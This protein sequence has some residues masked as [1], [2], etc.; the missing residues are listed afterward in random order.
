MAVSANPKLAA[1]ARRHFG[2][3]HKAL[4]ATGVKAR[5]YKIWTPELVLEEI[6]AW[7]RRGAFAAAVL[8]QFGGWHTALLA[9][10]LPSQTYR[11]WSKQRVIEELRV[12]YTAGSAWDRGLADAG[13]LEACLGNRRAGQAILSHAT[14]QKLVPAACGP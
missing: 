7:D 1:A 8:R 6:R 2:T 10:E 11:R 3:W 14:A 5:P 4:A 13:Q 9:A 12:W